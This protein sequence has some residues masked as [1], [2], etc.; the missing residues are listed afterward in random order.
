MANLGLQASAIPAPYSGGP[1]APS[2]DL[3]AKGRAGNAD[4]VLRTLATSAAL[5]VLLM[6]AALI[7]VL[8]YAA[9]PSV[10]AF[11]AHFLVGTTWRANELTFYKRDAKGRMLDDD[12]HVTGDKTEAAV[13]HEVGP[14]FGALPFIYG[15]VVSS[16]LALL[17]AIPL[18]CGGALF[19]VRVAPRIR[20]QVPLKNGKVHVV[21]VMA[22]VS[23]LI[24]F[25]AAIPSIAYGMWGIF[26]LAPFLQSHAEPALRRAL[27]GIPG[28]RWLFYG[29]DGQPIVLNGN[30]MLCGGLILAIMI[31]PIITAISRDVLRAVPRAQ[32]EGTQALGATWWQSSWEML[33]YSRSGLFG[34]VMLGLARAAGE[35]MAIAMVIGN[36]NQ[37]RPSLFAKAQTMSSLLAQE[38]KDASGLHRAALSEVA[39]VLLV[40]SLLF[41]I[42]A[43]YLVVGKQGGSAARH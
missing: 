35:T 43:R 10:K 18:S 13:D 5:C 7:A 22:P 41:N 8:A 2:N 14:T 26:V 24:E 42:V 16:G 28:F 32:I 36:M 21:Q 39:L 20:A 29:S 31:I 11:G 30:D 12:G 23:F 15:T 17:F 38:Y 37:I 4:F 19:L 9:V 27:G 3:T 1:E 33:R 40:M 25:L 6:L 34:A